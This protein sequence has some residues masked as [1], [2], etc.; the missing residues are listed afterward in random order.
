MIVDHKTTPNLQNI[1]IR[2]AAG[3]RVREAFLGGESALERGTR[4]HSQLEAYLRGYQRDALDA[5]YEQWLHGRGYG[6]S[7]AQ[8]VA[9]AKAAADLER[10]ITE[11]LSRRV[12]AVAV[13]PDARTP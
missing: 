2:T 10:R 4:I 12:A 8:R 13:L 7:E 9:E 3:R 6:K 11:R 1:P 5:M